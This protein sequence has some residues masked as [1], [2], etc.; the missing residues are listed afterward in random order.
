VKDLDAWIRFQ[1]Y[2]VPNV[3]G[4]NGCDIWIGNKHKNGYG[5]FWYDGKNR[6]SH[7]WIW[8]QEFGAIP[9]D[10]QINHLCY[11][12]ACVKLSHLELA[13]PQENIIHGLDG[14]NG[15][16][17]QHT[18]NHPDHEYKEMI[19]KVENTKTKTT[20]RCRTCNNQ[21]VSRYIKRQ[22]KTNT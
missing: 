3:G 14:P 12:R 6:K 20:I 11:N 7:R 13:T 1:K 18:K 17:A 8:E 22:R 5:I 10:L 16:I 9:E 2:I 15:R 19:I 4:P 21:N